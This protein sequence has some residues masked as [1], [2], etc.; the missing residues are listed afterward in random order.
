MSDNRKQALAFA[1]K[2]RDEVCAEK[3]K[4]VKPRI[5]SFLENINP[6]DVLALMM[7]S[8]RG[9][10][11]Q[12]LEKAGVS[13]RQMFMLE[14]DERVWNLTQKR[15]NVFPHLYGIQTTPYPMSACDGLDDFWAILNGKQFNLIYLDF[16]GRPQ[17]HEKLIRK[18]FVLNLV[19]P[20]ALM[21]MIFGTNR[22]ERHDIDISKIL[23]KTDKNM[24]HIPT[25][26]LIR[27]AIAFAGARM[28]KSIVDIPYV[29]KVSQNSHKY[30]V[31]IVNW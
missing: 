22:G 19:A 12:T 26:V 15:S 28:Y 11:V 21:M 9:P 23:M 10:E 30:V 7:P 1:V 27:N 29:S 8:Y 25:Q 2:N 6:K 17:T 14:R 31:T 24:K 18:L 20:Q 13:R 3:D 16:F 5:R 4:V